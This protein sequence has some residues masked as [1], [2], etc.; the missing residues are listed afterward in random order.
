MPRHRRFLLFTSAAIVV[1]SITAFLWFK[2]L[3]RPESRLRAER[4]IYALLFDNL[5]GQESI[6]Q[7]EA[8]TLIDEF[9]SMGQGEFQTCS[10]KWCTQ[11]IVDGLPQLSRNTLMDFLD[12]NR[13]SYP[14]KDYFS[15][16][17]GNLVGNPAKTSKTYW[18]RLS[19]SRIGFNPLLTQALVLVGDCRGDA[20]FA[21]TGEHMYGT[22]E[23][24][25]LHKSAGKWVIQKESQ[26]WITEKPS[27]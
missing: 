3:P 27:P 25:L 7:I 8:Y 5:K 17:V 1:L 16:T 20:C 9:T 21:I 24:I 13:Q 6:S 22:G 15:P 19:F 4:E 23:F 14:I 18:W 2:S 12:N 10:S 26:A 11:F